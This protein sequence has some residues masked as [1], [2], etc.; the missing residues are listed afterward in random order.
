MW[1]HWFRGAAHGLV[2]K[3][4]SK[5]VLGSIQCY[6]DL[7]FSLGSLCVI[8]MPVWFTF[9]IPK[10]CSYGKLEIQKFSMT[11]FNMTWRII[12]FMII[13]VMNIFKSVKKWDLNNDKLVWCK[14]T[15]LVCTQ[16]WSL[17]LRN[18]WL[19]RC[20]FDH[21]NTFS[22]IHSLWLKKTFSRWVEA[23]IVSDFISMSMV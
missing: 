23:V 8:P 22:H 13:K 12:V 17:N 1:L 18:V 6:G 16:H 3:H 9:H 4:H 11:L 5:Q 10:I 21:M 14:V 2:V 19:P 7:M 15:P 20:S